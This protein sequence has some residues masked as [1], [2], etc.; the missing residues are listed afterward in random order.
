MERYRDA[1]RSA[2]GDVNGGSRSAA[3]S[4]TQGAA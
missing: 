2:G 4:G 3:L 1:L